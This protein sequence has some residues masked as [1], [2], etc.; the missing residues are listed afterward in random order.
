MVVN[1]AES[2][3]GQKYVVERL[4]SRHTQE[5]RRGRV[6]TVWIIDRGARAPRLVT[7]YPKE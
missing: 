7:A 1:S 4:L 2:V 3:H 6:R 5:S